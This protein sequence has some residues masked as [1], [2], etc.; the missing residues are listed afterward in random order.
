MNFLKL[1]LT[2][3]M[4]LLEIRGSYPLVFCCC[5]VTKS[6]QTPCN[7][8]SC[9]T[10]GHLVPHH[11]PEFAQVHVHPAI[12]SSDT[13]FF[14]PSIFPSNRDF[15]KE[16]S[17][18]IRW[19]KYWSFSFSIS[20][21][22]EYSGFISFK[23]DCLDLHDVQRTFRNLL[24]HHSLKASIFWCSAFFMIQLSQPYMTTGK[25]INLTIWTFVGRM[26]L[27]FN[28]LSRFIIAFMPRSNCLLISWLQSPSAVILEPTKRKSVTAS[29]FSPS[30]SHEVMGPDAM[31]F[32][33]WMLSL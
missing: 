4:T 1:I 11:L 15:S 12:S 31:I 32:V 26:S 7:P 24:Q 25:A 18:H 6:C 23:I 3:T 16:L 29:T 5:L 17:V 13:V 20:P 22:N 27:L 14:L 33:F 2:Q 19:P 10:P 28:I 8:T 9:S 30:I 21:S